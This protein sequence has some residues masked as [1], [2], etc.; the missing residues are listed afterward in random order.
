MHGLFDKSAPR[1]SSSIYR[2]WGIEI[3]ASTGPCRGRADRV[4]DDPSGTRP[5]DIGCGPGRVRQAATRCRRPLRRPALP[6]EYE[7]RTVKAY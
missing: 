5:M 3:F 7:I 6:A 2:L 4:G 1:S